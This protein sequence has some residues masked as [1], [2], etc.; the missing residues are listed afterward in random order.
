AARAP[1]RVGRD[2]RRRRV[3]LLQVLGDDLRVEEDRVAV[4]QRGHLGARVQALERRA[5][6]LAG[7][8]LL[9]EDRPDLHRVRAQRVIVEL[10][11]SLL[12]RPGLCEIDA[13]T[14]EPD[15][16][17]RAGAAVASVPRALR[18]RTTYPA[19]SAATA[20]RRSTTRGSSVATAGSSREWRTAR[21]S[22]ASSRAT[23]NPRRSPPA[24]WR[25]RAR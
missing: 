8:R 4:D 9:V 2:E 7:D 21:R 14:G 18:R 5:L 6:A 22:A 1:G 12:V 15:S 25:R 19:D 13:V 23:A 10:H 20:P 3:R 16:R 11:R 24:R 17:A